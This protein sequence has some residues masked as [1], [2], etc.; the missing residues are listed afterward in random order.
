[1]SY[2]RCP[3]GWR[4]AGC[5]FTAYLGFNSTSE[6]E[7]QES[8]RGGTGGVSNET[9]DLE[10]PQAHHL[11]ESKVERDTLVAVEICTLCDF[12]K[13]LDANNAAAMQYE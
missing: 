8:V 4:L 2:L 5:N 1:V 9:I 12:T 11:K 7:E 10:W 13:V 3:S 6:K